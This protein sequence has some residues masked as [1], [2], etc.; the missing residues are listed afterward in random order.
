MYKNFETIR[1]TMITNQTYTTTLCFNDR[2]TKTHMITP[3]T[4]KN[5]IQRT[6]Y[7]IFENL[8]LSTIYGAS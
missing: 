5:Y 2:Q 8:Q 7:L 1:N 4:L 3:Y 6:L